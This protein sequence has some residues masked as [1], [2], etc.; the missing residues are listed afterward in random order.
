MTLFMKTMPFIETRFIIFFVLKPKANTHVCGLD[1]WRSF[2][3]QL[4]LDPDRPS[5]YFHTHVS[6]GNT[7]LRVEK[8]FIASEEAMLWLTFLL[9]YLQ[10]V[11]VQA[12]TCSSGKLT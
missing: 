6:S 2:I 5:K 11:R 9:F 12:A 1:S 10:I 7:S 4:T 3:A 8:R